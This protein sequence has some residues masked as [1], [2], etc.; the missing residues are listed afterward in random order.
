MKLFQTQKGTLLLSLQKVSAVH[1]LPFSFFL[2]I[3]S[4]SQTTILGNCLYLHCPCLPEYPYPMTGTLSLPL[5][6]VSI[7][8]L[9]PFSFFL[10]TF[11]ISSTIT[12]RN[13]LNL[14]F[15]CLM[16]YLM[17]DNLVR[18]LVVKQGYTKTQQ[19]V[20]NM[21]PSR[22]QVQLL[23]QHHFQSLICPFSSQLLP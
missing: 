2:L 19:L 16:S 22:L 3:F 15:H 18:L 5:Q 12:L 10:P 14:N 20:S 17:K 13:C 6:K 7:V 8:Q 1:L 4:I 11:F 23:Q 9:L 21:R